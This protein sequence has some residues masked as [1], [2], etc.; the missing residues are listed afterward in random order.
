MPLSISTRVRRGIAGTALIGALS[1]IASVCPAGASAYAGDE[2]AAT[3]SGLNI[4]ETPD[5]RQS[6][7][8][9]E[10]VQ[11]FA[12]FGDMRDYVL[13]PGGSFESRDLDGWQ[14]VR[15]KSTSDGSPLEVAGT[16]NRRSLKIAPGGSAI[17]PAMCV[18]LQYP[19]M[20]LMTKAAKE[21]GL[22]VDVVYPDSP[23]PTFQSVGTVSASPD[24]DWQASDDIPVFP[25]RG[26]ASAGMRRVALRFTSV[27]V[28][29]HFGDW[30]IDDVYV[31]PRR[32]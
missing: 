2:I 20:R 4:L 11:A 8:S 17:S 24:G 28:D 27:A 22:R 5:S 32:L 16:D 14:I 6:C 12:A 1:L 29:G 13:A 31:D 19:T 10:T 15:A 26:G 18:D 30:K 25:E 23:D 3:V 21:G 9:P 7:A